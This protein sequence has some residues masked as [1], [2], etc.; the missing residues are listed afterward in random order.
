MKWLHKIRV[1]QVLDDNDNLTKEE[2]QEKT[3]QLWE[4]LKMKVYEK[5]MYDFVDEFWDQ[6]RPET[7]ENVKDFN[8]LLE[9]LYNYCDW[10]YIWVD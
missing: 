4:L 9:Y 5:F 1:K 7:M 8:E 3:K 6:F 10:N 2:V